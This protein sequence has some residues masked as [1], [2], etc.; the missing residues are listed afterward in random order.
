[1]FKS[2]KKYFYIHCLFFKNCLMSQ[3]EYRF[4]FF[5]GILV[6]MLFLFDKV[7]YAIIVNALDISINGMKSDE[8]LLFIGS[9]SII[10]SIYCAFFLVN[11]NITLPNS[12]KNGDLD[13]LITK[14]ISTQFYVS[15]SYVEFA[16]M[17]P[18][19]IGGIII[20]VVACNRLQLDVTFFEIIGYI[21][22]VFTSVMT[23]YSIYF[24]IQLIS[25]YI[26]ETSALAGILNS[27]LDINNIP[28][29]A[30]GKVFRYIL[31]Y[32]FPVLLFG[33]IAPLF[34][35][36]QLDNLTLIWSI[37]VPIVFFML[38]KTGWKNIIRK[39]TSASS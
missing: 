2:I 37:L 5:S 24:F 32:V 18:D 22:F 12:I 14:P 33:N 31:T 26:T 29:R 13:I 11:L 34:L 4:N 19:L 1:M 36:G 7:I 35:L 10:L 3:M 39:Y 25:F 9:Y 23:I 15:T 17:I 21:F 16:T 8:V 28:F 38:G 6:D 27:L 30:Y 20:S